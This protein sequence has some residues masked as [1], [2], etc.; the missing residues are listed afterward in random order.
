MRYAAWHA[1][2]ML[3]EGAGARVTVV[4]VN[5]KY[6][7]CE[8]ELPSGVEFVPLLEGALEATRAINALIPA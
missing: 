3:R 1:A 4:R 5:P 7:L 8:H 6:P 2:T